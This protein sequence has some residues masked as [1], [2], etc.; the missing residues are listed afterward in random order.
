M[1]SANLTASFHTLGCRLNQAETDIISNRFKQNGY[2]IVDV[3]QP[4][5]VFVLNSC[6]VTEDADAKCRK[7]VRRVLRNNPKTFVVVVG[8]YAQIGSEALSKIHGI[9]LIVGTQDKLRVFE[10]FEDAPVKSEKPHVIKNK[11]T[12]AP[13]TIEHDGVATTTRAN[14][15]IQDG[16]DFMCSFC[17][18]PF[19]RGRARSRVFWDVQREAQQLVEAG[20]KEIILTGVNIG[21]YQFEDKTF[22]D[23]VKMLLKI[24]GLARLR[25]S[26]I[27]PTT[28][29]EQVLD[30]MADSDVFCPYLHI[31]AQSGNDEMLAKMKRLYRRDEFQRFIENAAKKIP[32]VLLGTDMMVGFPGEDESAFQDSCDLLENSPLAYA[33]VFTFSERSGTAA[34]RLTEKVSALEKKYRSIELHALSEKKKNSFY[35]RFI[36]RRLQV[37]TEKSDDSHVSAGYTRNYLRAV[38][39]RGGFGANRLVEFEALGLQDSHLIG[40]PVGATPAAAVSE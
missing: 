37:L 17:I 33:H 12:K 4:A 24:P 6:T 19:A 14:L 11:M 29:S 34:Q 28:I 2:K 40:E 3:D 5:D 26:S 39:P 25:I 18:I 32:D 21:T 7:L 30:L 15:K 35:R 38:L 36:G 20:H 10:F 22:L 13:F 16:C 27:E 8:C 9:D 31:P 1:T 23:V